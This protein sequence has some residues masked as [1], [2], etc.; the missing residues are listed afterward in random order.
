MPIL[1]SFIYCEQAEMN[2][3]NDK[4]EISNALHVFTLPALPSAFSFSIVFGIL[5][6]DNNREN[7]IRIVIISPDERTIVDTGELVIEK[8]ESLDTMPVDARGFMANMDFRNVRFDC[9]G[10]YITR[11]TMN[12]DLLGGYPIYVMEGGN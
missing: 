5:G 9:E 11:I 8:R 12:G 6:L 4:L 2:V 7:N 3:E 10:M 1:S